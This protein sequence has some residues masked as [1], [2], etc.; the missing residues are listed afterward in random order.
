LKLFYNI[1]FVKAQTTEECDRHPL[2][3]R[4]EIKMFQH[5]DVSHARQGLA[6][7][8]AVLNHETLTLRQSHKFKSIDFTF[9]AGN[10]V[11]E[12]TSSATF[13]LDPMSGRGVTWGQHIRSCDF[14]FCFFFVFS[15]FNRATANTHELIFAQN[16]SKDAVWCK[17]DT[18]WDDK[19]VIA[20]WVVFYQ[21]NTP[22]WL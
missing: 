3:V 17:E 20:K 18:F 5:T 6:V 19:F 8:K 12:V 11:R 15:F 16:S 1:N 22:I 13:S 9:G 7:L 14:C 10:Y 2:T 21:K 4:R